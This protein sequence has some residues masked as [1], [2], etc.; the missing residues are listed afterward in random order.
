M[1]L[2]AAL[3]AILTVLGVLVFAPPARAVGPVYS[4]SGW[5]AWTSNG[6]YSINPD[7]YVI[8]FASTTA[9]SKLTPYLTGPAGQITTATGV[10]VTV[11]TTIDTT[12]VGTCPARHRVIVSYSYRPT[13]VKGMSEARACHQTTD[14]SAWGGHLRM[15]SEYWTVASWFSTNATTNEAWRKDAVTHELGHIMGLAHP[16]VDLDKDGVVEARECVKNSA[17]LRPIMCSPNRGPVASTYGGKYT[18][19]FDVPGLRQMALNW[20]LRQP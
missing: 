19:E 10:R 9:R 4:G 16:N 17:G 18:S 14:G 13:G 7:P 20:Y 15:D 3:T 6:I 2:L 11:S 8:V 5:K 1:P 12:P